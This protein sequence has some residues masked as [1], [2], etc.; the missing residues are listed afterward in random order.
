MKA[1][2]K[3]SSNVWRKKLL[4]SLKR[5]GIL[6]LFLTLSYYASFSSLSIGN[7][8]FSFILVI[9]F[10]FNFYLFGDLVEYLFKIHYRVNSSINRLISRVLVGY[11]FVLIFKEVLPPEFFPHF[12]YVFIS[13]NFIYFSYPTR[14]RLHDLTMR[15]HF[16]E[17][18]FLDKSERIVLLLIILYFIFSIPFVGPGL[19]SSDNKGV[20]GI[21]LTIIKNNLNPALV[22]ISYKYLFYGSLLLACLYS[23]SRVFFSRRVCLLGVFLVQANWSFYKLYEGDLNILSY[24][25]LVNILF[26]LFFF[27]SKSLNYR[28]GL[29]FGI[30]LPASFSLGHNFFWSYAV[31][32]LLLLFNLR[33]KGKWYCLQ[34]LRYCSG[35]VVATF[36][37]FSSEI[38]FKFE[39]YYSLQEIV[40][41]SLR[42][43]FN[44]AF[45]INAMNSML[46]IFIIDLFKLN[47]LR[48]WFLNRRLDK[49]MFLILP[50]YWIIFSYF[51]FSE[52]NSLL[53]VLVIMLSF[54]SLPIAD[55]IIW[56]L[57][58]DRD[59]RTAVY[60]LFILF[61]L[62]DSHLEG[63]AKVF[64]SSFF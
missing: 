35:G 49:H 58:S 34:F 11:F 14:S 23:S 64:F 15:S 37:L 57:N 41:S 63:R 42:V 51:K 20:L 25:C 2:V 13:L 56:R 4:F 26:W 32:L 12:I 61:V 62:L 30:F 1:L 3:K 48:S 44:K 38:G 47:S 22:I 45:L 28:S 8:L 33:K 50:V 17:F 52:L 29:L 39:T 19:L 43:F 60:F 40:S 53:G 27:C 7:L 31:V 10:I 16:S 59:R 54:L 46:L 24:T 6:S 5:S 55:F 18:K 9:F 36:L 21:L